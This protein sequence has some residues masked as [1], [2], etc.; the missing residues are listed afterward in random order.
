MCILKNISL[1]ISSL[2]LSTSRYVYQIRCHIYANVIFLQIHMQNVAQ[3]L[4]ITKNLIL[5][6]NMQKQKVKRAIT[7]L[8]GNKED[9]SESY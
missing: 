1:D 5:I 6:E 2:K 7:S 8:M 3:L 4:R 9:A